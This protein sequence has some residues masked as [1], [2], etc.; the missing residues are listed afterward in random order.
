MSP[1]LSAR[2]GLSSRAYGQ[3]AASTGV[4]DTGVMFPLGMVQVGSAGSATISFTSIPSTYKHLQI[5]FIARSEYAETISAVGI[6]ITSSNTNPSYEHALFG[7]GSDAFVSGSNTY[8]SNGGILVRMAGNNATSGVYGV[9]VIDI[10]DY[11]N[12]NKNKTIRG[13]SGLDNNGSGQLNLNSKLF[14]TTSSID[15]IKLNA[16]Y[17][18]GSTGTTTFKQYTQFALYGIKG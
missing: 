5:R 10:L 13:L 16:I 9:G 2:G 17:T 1:I 12:T 3:F 4:V 15:Q 8:V 6:Q 18:S 7:D 11:T 14:N